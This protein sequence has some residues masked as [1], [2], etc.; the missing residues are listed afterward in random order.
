MTVC[1]LAFVRL[2]Y[3]SN[4]QAGALNGINLSVEAAIYGVPT[5]DTQ[6]IQSVYMQYGGG[7]R[8][9]QTTHLAS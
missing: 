3:P 8:C 5:Q 1:M 9:L 7:I 4:R 2:E 6:I